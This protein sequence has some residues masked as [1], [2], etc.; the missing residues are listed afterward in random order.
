NAPART[1]PR[2]AFFGIRRRP[3]S[4]RYLHFVVKRAAGPKSDRYSEK[5]TIKGLGISNLMPYLCVR[6]VTVP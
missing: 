4:D 3:P 6:F 2:R 1:P 5:N